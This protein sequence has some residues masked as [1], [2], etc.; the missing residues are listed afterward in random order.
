V[1]SW[2]FVA[3]WHCGSV[4][5]NFHIWA[6]TDSKFSTF[7]WI[8]DSTSR[9]NQKYFTFKGRIQCLLPAT[10]L[11]NINYT[12][13]IY[14]PWKLNLHNEATEVGKRCI[15]AILNELVVRHRKLC[16]HS[17]LTK[18]VHFEKFALGLEWFKELAFVFEM[19]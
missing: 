5:T 3:T 18:R 7:I 15:G 12:I 19:L 6:V 17:S 2:Q 10:R 11:K 16:T 9:S 1:R 14:N 4:V 8:D 13:L